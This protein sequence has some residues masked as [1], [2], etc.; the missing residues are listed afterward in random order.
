MLIPGEITS[1]GELEDLGFELILPQDIYEELFGVYGL[2]DDDYIIENEITEERY[3]I[4][5]MGNGLCYVKK[6]L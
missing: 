6:V 1:F 5:Y 2:G 4:K 3:V